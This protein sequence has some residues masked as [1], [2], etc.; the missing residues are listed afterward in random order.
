M[1]RQRLRRFA[2][3]SLATSL[4]AVAPRADIKVTPVVA[5]GRVLV[6]FAAP[7]SIGADAHEL[8]QSGLLMTL[9]FT[10]DLK[11]PSTAWFDRGLI[12]VTVSSSVKFV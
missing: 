4:A 12:Q 2:A 11:Q 7:T 5:D 9:T 10:V 8:V 1:N 3:F 6:S